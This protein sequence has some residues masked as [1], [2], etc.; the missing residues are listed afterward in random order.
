MNNNTVHDHEPN[1]LETMS[2]FRA[3]RLTYGTIVIVLWLATEVIIRNSGIIIGGIPYA[4]ITFFWLSA[5][6]AVTRVSGQEADEKEKSFLRKKYKI[7][8]NKDNTFSYAGKTFESF[9][10]ALYMARLN[11]HKNP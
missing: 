5:L 9:D 10:E 8:Q 6:I 4:I 7:I 3:K 2:L 1:G 11:R